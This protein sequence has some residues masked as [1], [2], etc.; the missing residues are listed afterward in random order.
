M[1]AAGN[2][3]VNKPT[4]TKS[5]N[6]RSEIGFLHPVRAVISIDHETAQLNGIEA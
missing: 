2:T 6:R 1:T 5:D 4:D 3:R